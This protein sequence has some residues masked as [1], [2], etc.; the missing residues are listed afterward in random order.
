MWVRFSPSSLSTT[1]ASPALSS[2]GEWTTALDWASMKGALHDRRL[3]G[4]SMM[5]ATT[6]TATTAMEVKKTAAVAGKR[7]DRGSF[8]GRGGGGDGEGEGKH[9]VSLCRWTG[10]WRRG[11]VA[12]SAGGEREGTAKNRPRHYPQRGQAGAGASAAGACRAATAGI[13]QGGRWE[14]RNGRRLRSAKQA[15]AGTSAERAT[16]REAGKIFENRNA[17]KAKCTWKSKPSS[18][19]YTPHVDRGGR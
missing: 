2:P 14:L 9:A 12:G 3:Y 6:T 10:S 18:S 7:N 1:T 4:G 8:G 13:R 17:Q 19:S 15:L 16:A 5:L 11:L